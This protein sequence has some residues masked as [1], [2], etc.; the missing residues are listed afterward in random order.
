MHEHAGV[1]KWFDAWMDAREH[2]LQDPKHLDKE[3]RL[4]IHL[5]QQRA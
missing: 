4:Y 2:P 3:L 5:Q 1:S